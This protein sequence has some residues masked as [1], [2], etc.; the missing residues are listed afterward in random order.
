MQLFSSVL[1]ICKP[2]TV[3]IP[4]AVITIVQ[5]VVG[6]INFCR[7]FFYAMHVFLFSTERYDAIGMQTENVVCNGR[8]H[9]LA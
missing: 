5:L 4:T 7:S 9:D 1:P 6:G 8:A 3:G 2:Y